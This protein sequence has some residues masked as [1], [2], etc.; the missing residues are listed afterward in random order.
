MTISYSATIDGLTAQL[1]T[2]FTYNF[3]EKVFIKNDQT[4]FKISKKA[5]KKL[6]SLIL[7]LFYKEHPKLKVVLDYLQNVARCMADLDLPVVWNTPAGVEI[8]QKYNERTVVKVK[9]SAYA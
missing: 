9:S 1:L 2:F 7:N 3:K 8:T 6:A 4:S 5:L